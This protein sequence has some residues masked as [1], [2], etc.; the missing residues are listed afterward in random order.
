MKIDGEQ[1]SDMEVTTTVQEHLFHLKCMHSF[2]KKTYLSSS[3]KLFN[4]YKVIV[5]HINVS[6]LTTICANIDSFLFES[7]LSNVFFFNKLCALQPMK[8]VYLN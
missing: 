6:I 1:S 5:T 3:G 4:Y 8:V 2:R 7:C